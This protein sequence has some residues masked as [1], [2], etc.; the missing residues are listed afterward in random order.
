MTNSLWM[1]LVAA[2]VIGALDFCQ[3]LTPMACLPWIFVVV[4]VFVSEAQSDSCMKRFSGPQ[5]KKDCMFM[6]SP[7]P[8][9]GKQSGDL[10]STN[11]SHT[12]KLGESDGT[13]VD[14]VSKDTLQVAV[15][16]SAKRGVQSEGR[17]KS[18]DVEKMHGYICVCGGRDVWFAG[19]DVEIGTA[20]VVGAVVQFELYFGTN[21][22][23]PRARLVKH[24]ECQEDPE[25]R[26]VMTGYVKNIQ[27]GHCFLKCDG[28][29]D[30]V[31]VGWEEFSYGV[32]RYLQKGQTL[33]FSL[34]RHSPKP[35]AQHV[36]VVTQ[37]T[38]GVVLKYF[39]KYHYGFLRL[40]QE[41]CPVWFAA[42][43]VEGEAEDRV[44]AD[45]VKG[46]E[47]DV[48]YF[49]TQNGQLRAFRVRCHSAPL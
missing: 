40:P 30:D 21:N 28:L 8:R 3:C 4:F 49:A 16:A 6:S 41:T 33:R 18:F 23:K 9:C 27:R 7:A 1:F 47:V 22:G 20:I 37:K 12:R 34:V 2:I 19:S 32:W 44:P 43:C 5:P 10:N 38:S 14:G 45:L 36:E 24:V 17:I 39:H 48:E 15:Q 25:P 29:T 13:A 35:K 31:F 42:A 26:E 46:A 11:G